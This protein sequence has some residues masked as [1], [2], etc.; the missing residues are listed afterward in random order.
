M[1]EQN[2]TK[3]KTIAKERPFARAV[4]ILRNVSLRPTRQRLALAKLLF[5]GANRHVTAESLHE[6]ID[7]AQITIS[8]ATIYNTS[9]SIHR[10]GPSAGSGG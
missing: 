10:G 4:Q 3:H 5:E 1:P 9:A 6:E 7:E 2:K 8:R